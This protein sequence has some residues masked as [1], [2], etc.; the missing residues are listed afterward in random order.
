[1]SKTAIYKSRGR[2]DKQ[3]ANGFHQMIKDI[4]IGAGDIL[5]CY[6]HIRLPEQKRQDKVLLGTT[7]EYAVIKNK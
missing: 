1:M 6:I 3:E 5:S 2:K 7:D 4:P